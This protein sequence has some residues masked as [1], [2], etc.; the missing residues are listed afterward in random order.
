M[1]VVKR[2]SQVVYT[3]TCWDSR[4]EACILVEDIF[5]N[6]ET[7]V[8]Y[9]KSFATENKRLHNNKTMS[10]L[11][12]T[13]E[14]TDATVHCLWWECKALE[15]CQMHDSIPQMAGQRHKWQE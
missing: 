2:P 8:W 13:R 5:V 3:K 10:V 12:E 9:D 6:M 15:T 11:D 7:V 4:I 14:F 1:H